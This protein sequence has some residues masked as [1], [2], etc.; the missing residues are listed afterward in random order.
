[1]VNMSEIYKNGKKAL[2]RGAGDLATGVGIALHRAGFQVIMTEIAKPLTVRREVAMSR[3][4]YEGQT[5]VEGVEGILVSDYQ[6]AEE[7]LAEDKIPVI[8]DPNADIRYEFC[9]DVLVDAILAKKNT[10]TR[11]TDAPYVIGLGP[12]F[13]AGKDVHAVIETMRGVTLA[14]VI[15]DGHPIPNT[16]VPGYVGGYALER[17]LRASGNGKME[18]EAKIGDMVRKGQLVAVT[19]GEPVYAQLDGV[20]RGMLQE[21]VMV[22]KGLKIGDVDPRKDRSLC[23]LI[24]DK[25]NKIGESVVKVSEERL[26]DEGY[27][28]IVLA[29]GKSS[30]Y[31]NNKLLEELDG[32][33]MFEHTLRKMRAFPFCTQVIVTRFDQIK[34][35]A[36]DQKMCVVENNRPDLGIAYSLKL[37]L[38]RALKEKPELKGAMFIVCD[39]P[40]LTAGT[41]A[42]MLD[43]SKK[44]PGKIVCA[45]R[46][47]K[48]GNPVLWDR[49]FFEELM[50][51]SGDKGG[52]QIMGAHKDDVLICETERT[53]L[54]DI[55]EPEQLK[56][57]EKHYGESGKSGEET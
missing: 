2:V 14:D 32:G 23:Y 16:G 52:K 26:S 17:L 46:K 36:E 49:K 13:T 5:K 38:K 44:N 25:A 24:S 22:K 19:G 55:D 30:R 28:M 40:G 12:G 31:G 41:F 27:A 51:L 3:A 4:V 7:V 43:M 11:R 56:K 33:Q 39:Q 34:K 42:R 47:K 15:Y 21:G 6:E 54:Q 29:A 10:G 50:D 9:P 48:T 37:G 20:V 35:A 8:I 57:W 53:E 45:G 18:P 1:M